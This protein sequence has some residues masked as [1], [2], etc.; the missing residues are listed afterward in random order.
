VA[1]VMI[2]RPPLPP[3]VRTVSTVDEAVDWVA[4]IRPDSAA[5]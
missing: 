2:D 1:V 3:G 4:G 5:G